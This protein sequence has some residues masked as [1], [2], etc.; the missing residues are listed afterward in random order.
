MVAPRTQLHCRS[1]L[2]GDSDSGT[3]PSISNH[4]GEMAWMKGFNKKKVA[5]VWWQK[6]LTQMRTVVVE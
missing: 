6:G 2:E 3:D 1:V 4:V 5:R